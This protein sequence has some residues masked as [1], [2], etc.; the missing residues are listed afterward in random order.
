MLRPQFRIWIPAR[1]EQ[2]Q[3]WPDVMAGRNAEKYVDTLFESCWILLVRQVVEENA[4]RIH[5]QIL[6]PAKLQIDARR[7]ECR[8]LPHFQRVDG[9]GRH[10]ITT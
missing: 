10:V 1:I 9:V 4:H 2:N 8:C 3:N 5:P 6:S 7:I